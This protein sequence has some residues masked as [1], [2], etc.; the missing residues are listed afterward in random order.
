M[1]P[2]K[3]GQLIR[4]LRRRQSLT[5]RELAEQ[6]HVTDKTIS[7]WETG[8][9]C[10]DI[11]LLRELAAL[12]EVSMETLLRGEITEQEDTG[13]MK[14][15][16]FYVC[17][18]CGNILTSSADAEVHCCGRRLAPLTPQKAAEPD[19][20]QMEA[21]DGEWYI[22]SEHAMTKDNYIA[23]VACLT[24][25]SLLLCRQYPEWGLQVRMPYFARGRL[26]WYST[27]QGLLYQDI[28]IRRQPDANGIK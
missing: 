21:V 22:T 13:N 17:P 23:F 11:T 9:G 19:L 2:I 20:L 8:G 7:K 24:D 18:D 14:K 28:F 26:L 4:R 3:T 1:D 27:S 25:S 12:F 15:L 6:L 16:R 10:P 5:Q